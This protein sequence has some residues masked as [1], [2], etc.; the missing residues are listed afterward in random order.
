[1][2]LSPRKAKTV[3]VIAFVLSLFFFIFTLVLG[4]FSATLSMYLLSWQI[5]AGVLVWGVLI[6]QFYQRTLAEQ[7]K[8][9]AG[10]LSKAADEG[11]IFSG[12][13][14]RMAMMAVAQKRL[15]FLEKWVVPVS[16]VLIGIYQVVM[17]LLLFQG[18]VLKDTPEWSNPKNL[19]LSAVLMATVSFIAFLFSRYTTGMSAE[20]AWKPL[21]AGGSYLLATALLGFA[22]AISLALAQFKHSQGLAV[23]GYVIPLLLMLLG[24][25]VVLNAILDV[26]RP[27]VA[28]Q[29]SRAA[30]DSRILGMFNEPG[31]ILHTVSHTID[32]QFG[33][34]VSQTWFY[35]LLEKA[36][37]PL[38]LFALLILYLMSSFVVIG[39]GQ[40]GVVER[41]GVPV[42][43]L[44]P[45]LHLKCPWPIEIVYVH[46]V[47]QIQRFSI[48]YKEGEAD[49][50]KKAFLWGEK[51]Y[52]EEYNLLVAVQT[53]S[54]SDD[55]GA[56]PVSIVQ[57][58]VPV[59][60]RISDV[61]KYIYNH[62]DSR[63][64]LEAICYR[65]LT[66]YAASAKI[67]TDDTAS[68]GQ[69]SLLGA[70]RIEAAEELKRRIQ[71][72][73]N[74]ADLGVEIV[75]LGLQGVHPPPEVAKEY[76]DVVASVQ[77]KQAM[78][79]N[80]LAE[81]NRLLTELGGSIAEVDALYNLALEFERSKELGDEQKTEQ[82][83]NELQVAFGRVKGRVFRTLRE[84]ESYAFERV[85]L[86]RG[87]G[88][89]F[90]GQLQAYH[91]SPEIYKKLQRLMTLEE[92]LGGVR[93]YVVVTDDEDAQVYIVDLQEKL[94]QSLYDM[95]M[96]LE[97]K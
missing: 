95:D 20:T 41:Y 33:F 42:R 63:E 14:D 10:Q 37:F 31:G 39:P 92:T 50:E 24:V 73:V 27:R 80:A 16:A 1:M 30:F 2:N 3:S 26:Y 87:E 81:K 60:F 54:S 62:R 65:E 38:I 47:D 45:G 79:L 15:V 72:A 9:D 11:T 53:D 32:Y 17:G 83:K 51:H 78:V 77:E 40:A 88:L 35:K 96:G 64:L 86:A 34:Q 85:N 59:L 75:L 93:K 48:G 55:I 70:G 89:R 8:L 44:E 6:A 97:E 82:L 13:A 71:N 61:R 90:S 52:E 49:K 25:E 28:G 21:R 4:A 12:G 19:L 84:A 22:L 29:Y 46:P 23:L 18:K 67:E 66:R 74:E 36:I 68:N 58:S 56:A 69:K 91:A 5:L 76:E 43:D 7:E 57:A 94:K